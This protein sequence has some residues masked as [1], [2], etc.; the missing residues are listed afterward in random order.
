MKVNYRQEFFDREYTTK[1]AYARL[2]AFARR[3]KF[4]LAMGVFCGVLTA[5]T[6]VPMFGM[7]QPTLAKVE[8]RQGEAARAKSE[9]AEAKSEAKGL[10]AS[11]TGPSAADK[12][13]TKVLREYG[14]VQ[15]W[16]AKIGIEMQDDDEAMGLP[17][18]FAVII[19]MPLVALVRL[20]LVFLNHYCLA[21]AGMKTVRDIRC[22][23]LRCVNAQ[24]M[25]FHGRI[26]VGQIGRAH[27]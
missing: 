23:L 1:E 6:L 18:L 2:W 17:L 3:Y 19:L 25:Q 7:I 27:V 20:G 12:Q 16:A 5:G 22:E 13:A 9:G 14:K 10:Q 21:W 15:K 8:T 24:S 4:R 11:A 26:D